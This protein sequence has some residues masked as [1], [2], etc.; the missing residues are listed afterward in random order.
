MEMASQQRVPC[1]RADVAD[2]IA[3]CNEKGPTAKYTTA[4]GRVQLHDRT[5]STAP[6]LTTRRHTRP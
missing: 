2:R 6:I 3:L 1:N 4:N 5:G